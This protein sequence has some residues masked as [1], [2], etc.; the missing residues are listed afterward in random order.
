MT[1]YEHQR[2]YFGLNLSTSLGLSTSVVFDI[3]TKYINESDKLVYTGAMKLAEISWK[4]HGFKVNAGIIKTQNFALKESAWGHRYVMASFDGENKFSPSADLGLSVGYDINDM[5]SVDV[6]LTNG[7][8]HQKIELTGNYRY[9]VGL[10]A[11]LT[12]EIT[13]RAFYDHYSDDGTGRDQVCPSLFAGYKVS[14]FDMGVEYTYMQNKSF[15]E[16]V[17]AHGGSIYSTY[18]F[19]KQVNAY[20]RY[21]RCNTT[22]ESVFA[23]GN[24]FRVGAEYNPFKFLWLSPSIICDQNNSDA[25]TSYLHLNLMVKF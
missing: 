14:K 17:A 10:T 5:F 19:T 1:A 12:D 23:S 7:K 11:K 16:G 20:A 6:N 25:Y 21:D 24:T 9:G 13:L 4:G 18:H 3:T 2:G 15:V 8:G 22:D